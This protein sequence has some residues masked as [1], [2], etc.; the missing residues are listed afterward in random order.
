MY[1]KDEHCNVCKKNKIRI[2]GKIMK[3]KLKKRIALLT[4]GMTVCSTLIIS[5]VAS[6][7]TIVNKGI[8]EYNGM[9]IDRAYAWTGTYE[10]AFVEATVVRTSDYSVI[11]DTQTY[12]GWAQNPQSSYSSTSVM[13]LHASVDDSGHS[14]P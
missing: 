3:L 7:N 1:N 4:L 10:S 14:F 9:F 13:G 8:T 11:V 2:G 6:A 5:N 12:N